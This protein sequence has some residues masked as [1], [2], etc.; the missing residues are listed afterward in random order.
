MIMVSTPSN[1]STTDSKPVSS[2]I[3]RTA[4]SMGCP[5]PSIPPPGNDQP[6]RPCS[7]QW[8]SRMWSSR[9]ITP[10]AAIRMSTQSPYPHNTV[11]GYLRRTAK[12]R[13][14]LGRCVIPLR[15]TDR[16]PG[17]RTIVVS[18][19]CVDTTPGHITMRPRPRKDQLDGPAHPTATSITACSGCRRRYWFPRRRDRRR[20]SC[21]VAPPHPGNSC[22]HRSV[23][24][25]YRPRPGNTDRNPTVASMAAFSQY[26]FPRPHCAHRTAAALQKTTTQFLDSLQH[27]LASHCTAAAPT[28]HLSVVPP[29]GRCAVD[30]ERDHLYCS[31]C[32]HRP[33]ASAGAHRLVSGSSCGVC[34]P[35]VRLTRLAARKRMG[36]IQ[37]TTADPLHHGGL[38]RGTTGDPHRP[39]TLSRLAHRWMARPSPVRTN[40][41]RHPL[42]GFAVLYRIHNR[43]CR[44][45]ADNR[46]VPQPQSDVRCARV[47]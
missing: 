30:H 35:A 17:I 25:C 33:V 41:A 3:S 21:T 31:A 43:P 44:T 40:G 5:S 24:G 14:G 1:R 22:L 4:A 8:A 39:A 23:P 38:Y 7:F 32:H 46:N 16:S 13:G 12:D 2:R 45:R 47:R 27:S 36:G 37:R 15:V 42:P 9:T 20:G 10:Y 29:V 19:P 11:G 6:L 18:S 28:Q 26:T 34:C